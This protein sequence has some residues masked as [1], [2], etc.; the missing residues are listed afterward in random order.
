M[1]SGC[2][3]FKVMLEMSLSFRNGLA[4]SDTCHVHRYFFPEVVLDGKIGST[5]TK[6][7]IIAYLSHNFYEI[8][9]ENK[10]ELKSLWIIKH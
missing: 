8:F 1:C 3:V 7:I 9:K 5:V 2:L 4:Y 6:I 10:I